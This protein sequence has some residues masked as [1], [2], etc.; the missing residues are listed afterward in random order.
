MT[1]QPYGNKPLFR[2]LDADEVGDQEVSE[3]ESL[4]MNCEQQGTT[5]L[6]LTK[7]PL[8]KDV[9]IMSF[10]CPHCHYSN[11]ELQP[12][13]KI[14][15]KGCNY[16]FRITN[17]KD[18]N[19]MVIKS[20]SACVTIP[21]LDFEIPSTSQKGTV[22]TVEGTLHR[23]IAGLEQEQPIRKALDPETAEKIEIFID[24][25]KK[26]KN[27]ENPFTFIL[28]DPSGNSYIEN[29]FAPTKDVAMT[30]THYERSDEQNQ[31]LGLFN[32]TNENEEESRPMTLGGDEEDDNVKEEVMIFQTN[33]TECNSPTKTNMK[34]VPIPNFKEVVIMATVCDKCGY[35]TSEVKSGSGIEEKGKKISLKI[36]DISDMSRDLLKS[37]TCM[38]SIPELEMETMMGTLGSKF[39]TIEGLLEDIKTQL[40]T[41]NPLVVGDSVGS[42]NKQKM[43]I[44]L[45]KL[46]KVIGCELPAT[47][48]LD[49]PAGNS[50]LQNIYAPEDDPN[51]TV[52]EYERND[53][54][55]DELGI[56][57]MKTEN[58]ENKE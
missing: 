45:N 23:A 18:M 21:E 8:Y 35:K 38:V 22:T 12:A 4:C 27:V 17:I 20:D 2:N 56:K 9:V 34:V 51:M 15:N 11:N 33:C 13:G 32:E 25:M 30:I 50:Y 10:E 49:D 55:N 28:D 1:E 5:K 31:M 26:L 7:I 40:K 6:L 53:E 29:L 37:D 39:T 46:D 44:F 41:D 16:V 47:I 3:I 24:K 57:D 52:E 54:Q 36:T 42:E 48:I 58:Y 14:Q 19:R 43:E